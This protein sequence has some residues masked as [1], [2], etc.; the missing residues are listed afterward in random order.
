[1]PPKRTSKNDWGKL[2]ADPP[3]A[4]IAPD[5]DSI[6][7]LVGRTTPP[8][9]TPGAGDPWAEFPRVAA[10]TTPPVT[11]QSP[12]DDS[13]DWYHEMYQR[14][15]QQQAEHG[16]DFRYQQSVQDEANSRGAIRGSF[17]VRA[18]EEFAGGIVGKMQQLSATAIGAAANAVGATS[19]AKSMQGQRERIAGQAQRQEA[20]QADLD[21]QSML[22]ETASRWGRQA[23]SGVGEAALAIETGGL[24]TLAAWSGATTTA[25]ASAR[26]ESLPQAALHGTIDAAMTYA[27]GKF[28]GAGAGVLSKLGVDF[29]KTLAGKAAAYL[30]QKATGTIQKSLADITA[31]SGAQAA[32]N[33]TAAVSHY[34]VDTEY[35]EKFSWD[36]LQRRTKEAAGV[37]ALTGSAARITNLAINRLTD[38]VSVPQTTNGRTIRNIA[39]KVSEQPDVSLEVKANDTTPETQSGAGAA[40]SP[41]QTPD[42]SLAGGAV[43][44]KPQ[45]PTGKLGQFSAALGDLKDRTLDIPEFTNFR[46]SVLEWSGRGQQSSQEIHTA[47]KSIKEAVPDP[48]R[49]AAITNYIQAGGDPE[50]LAARAATSSDTHKVGYEA[51]QQLTPEEIKVAEGIKQT[52]ADMRQRAT[53][54]GI[55]INEL[56]DYVNQLWK[57]PLMGDFRPSSGR[58]LDTSIRF[59]K[60]R[61]HESFYHGEQAGLTPQTKDIAQLLPVY[62]NEVNNAI[63]SKQFVAS[64]LEGKAKDG[65]P[66]LA[67]TGMVKTVDDP[68]TGNPSYFVLPDAPGKAAQTVTKPDGTTE[69]KAVDVPTDDYRS[70]DQ[71]ALHS[72]TWRAADENGNPVFV[73]GDL[74]VHPEVY[75]HLKNVLGQSAIREWWN[76]PSETPLGTLGKKT[77]KFLADDVQQVGKA[78]ML[79]FLSPFHQVQ[80]GTHAVGHRVNPFFNLP[81]IDLVNDPAQMDAAQHGLMLLP[82]RVSAAQF[83][84]GLDGSSK[85]LMSRGIGKVGDVLAKGGKAGELAGAPFTAV[86]DWSDAYQHYLFHEYIPALKLKTYDHMLERNKARYADELAS[87]DVSE[88]QVK[89]L[90]SQQANAAYGH[91][92]YADM[93]RDQTVMHIMRMF[94]LAPDFLESRLRFVGQAAK[95]TVS[96]N[97]REQLAAIGTLA[98]V[99]WAGSRILNQV[100]DGDPHNDDPFAV[101]AGNRR[102]VMRSVPE[103]ILSAFSDTRKFVYGRLSPYVGRGLVEGLSGV[104]YRGEPTTTRQ[105]FRD[106]VA[107]TVPL[108]LQ[109][110][111]RGLSETSKDNPVSPLEQ[112]LGSVGVHVSRYSPLSPI[113]LA[114]QKWIDANGEK[115]GINKQQA[116]FPI[117]KYQQ[118]RY[119]LDDGDMDRATAEVKRVMADEHITS[120]QLVDRV[121]ESLKRPFTGSFRTDRVFRESLDDKGK[122]LYD[123]ARERQK[124][125]IQRFAVAMSHRD[126]TSAS[127]SQSEPQTEAATSGR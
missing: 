104:N 48:V 114:A 55:T 56:P 103:D 105:M 94:W 118:L 111:T 3:P 122:Q 15:M 65:R 52:Y 13:A 14:E 23:A 88:S 5:W 47:Q 100:I 84:E 24:P 73:Q 49:R 7:E 71:R 25:D 92:N 69:T 68:T 10:Q 119:A 36:E 79:G 57:Q 115:Y 123:A 28:L 50:T 59:A 38:A 101:H 95:G 54:L 83:K 67:S 91:L 77:A 27:G 22:G 45:A 120:H 42:S 97:G 102:Y 93:G 76:S 113:H 32:Q 96:A 44:G 106:L 87:G 12:P 66:L 121:K 80:E 82:D 39:R 41:Q 1:M 125:L 126:D 35:G 11:P 72:W 40:A 4:P 58:K 64:M 37:G 26:G 16:A 124:L 53:D 18:A 63:N 61:Y 127:N 6:G 70:L 34:L 2:L 60:Q 112:F 107:G 21:K 31:A 33:V 9:V 75:H 43:E 8:V 85:N 89:Y 30:S 109:P 108:T 74:R 99:Q 98:A 17:P 90:S 46:K 116:V 78:T 20:V 81:K 86:K 19:L 117:S 51:A 29:D 110:L 62:I